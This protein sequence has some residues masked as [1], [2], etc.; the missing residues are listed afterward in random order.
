MAFA[1]VIG[2]VLIY[3]SAYSRILQPTTF[4]DM[5]APDIRG[6]QEAIQ[7]LTTIGQNK[8]HIW[9]QSFFYLSKFFPLLAILPYSASYLE[10]RNLNFYYFVTSRTSYT[11]Y[12]WTKF[13]VNF[14]IGGL[15]IFIPEFIFYTVISLVFKNEVLP[16]FVFKPIGFLS[17]VFSTHPELY[18]W[19]TF[20]THFL[21]GACFASIALGL[22]CFVKPKIV[23]YVAPF[24][25]YIISGFLFEAIFNF[26]SLSPLQWFAMMYNTVNPGILYGSVIGLILLSLMVY[27]MRTRMVRIYG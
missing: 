17:S 3:L 11:K 8:Y 5:N 10:E 14:L 1:I 4:A 15:A 20:A 7:Y 25:F 16:S 23:V 2:L 6:N 13:V 12:T 22:S 9:H 19:V 26:V 27:T 18:I 24:L 21:L